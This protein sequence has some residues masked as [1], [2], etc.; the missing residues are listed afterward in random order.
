M[1]NIFVQARMTSKRLPGKVL[2]ELC[3]K[4]ILQHITERVSHKFGNN[5]MVILTSDHS[6]DLPIVKF[7][8]EH[9]LNIYRG[10]LE[11]VYERFKN[12]IQKYKP[13]CFVR[14]CGD[15]PLIDTGLI[16]EA[17][18]IYKN[19]KA[20]LVTNVFPRSFPKGQSVEVIKTSSF[21]SDE[22]TKC[23]SFS[24][25]HVTSSFYSNEKKFDIINIECT[26]KN[27]VQ[28]LAVDS[29]ED[30]LK[31]EKYLQDNNFDYPKFSS[32]KFNMINKSVKNA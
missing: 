25:E 14:V 21:L 16:E 5:K 28:D 8:E 2:K 26:S 10:S 1:I 22:F 7:A 31:I 18:N 32:N 30:F 29:E 3:G 9:N 23:S 11:N 24:K 17:I 19:N 6:T 20:D 12:A 4:Y 13:D 15:S 27:L